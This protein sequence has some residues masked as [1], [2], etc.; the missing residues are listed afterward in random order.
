MNGFAYHSEKK[1]FD[2]LAKILASKDWHTDYNQLINQ[3]ITDN[4]GFSL[5]SFKPHPSTES[6]SSRRLSKD[7]GDKTVDWN[8]LQNRQQEAWWQLMQL[9]I[10]GR[11]IKR[12]SASWGEDDYRMG[13]GSA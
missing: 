12:P 2:P 7:I 13:G 10:N 11:N 1:L 6:V 9:F 3:S 8:G 5:L 4:P